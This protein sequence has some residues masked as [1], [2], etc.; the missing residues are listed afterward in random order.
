VSTKAD[1][2]AAALIATWQHL[3]SAIPDGWSSGTPGVMAAVTGIEIPTLNGVWIKSE[4][5]DLGT[6]ADLL[7]QVAATGLPHC[8][9]VR[10]GASS[11][12]AEL[13]SARGMN[14]DDH[15]IPLMVLE[16]ADRP[17]TPQAV[18]LQIREL[19]HDEAPIH[20]QT[21]AAGFEAPVEP[22][23]QL[24]TPA[25]LALPGVHCYLGEVD[26]Q[27]VTTGLGVVT[28][29]YAGIF[30]IATPP[31]SRRRGYGAA[32]TARA[33]EDAF[34][35]GATWAFL[36][37]SAPGF[38]IYEA[39]GFRTAEEWTCWLSPTPGAR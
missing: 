4:S 31:E 10:P 19:G 22:F 7:D 29:A 33:V 18:G 1:T 6:T 11:Q 16:A 21:A 12:I 26:G 15:L 37:S 24:M 14:R 27:P 36:Q 38:R 2:V 13:A 32:V 34:K 25:I 39:L 9:Q 28:G 23:L 17:G 20:A 8:L 5:V 30:N 35:G 3:V